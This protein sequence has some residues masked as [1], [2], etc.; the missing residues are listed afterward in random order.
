MP[1]VLTGFETRRRETPASRTSNDL[2]VDVPASPADRFSWMLLSRARGL[3]ADPAWTASGTERQAPS[4]LRRLLWLMLWPALA[5]TAGCGPDVDS[6]TASPTTQTASVPEATPEAV[7]RFCGDCHATPPPESFP[8]DAW[9]HEV[10]QGYNF[11]YESLRTDLQP[12][13]LQATVNFFVSRAPQRLAECVPPRPPSKTVELQRP[14]APPIPAAAHVRWLDSDSG[15]PGLWVCDMGGGAVWNATWN[16]NRAEFAWH[17]V[18]DVPHPCR[19]T[20]CDVDGSATPQLVVADLGS[21]LPEDHDRGSVWWLRRSPV[22]QASWTAEPLATGLARV[23]DVRPIDVEGDGDQDLIVAEFGWRKSGQ[24]RLLV[25]Q[26][27]DADGVPQFESRTIDKRHGAIHVPVIDL[28]ADGDLDFVALIAQE[29]EAIVAFLNDGQGEFT[30]QVLYR[31]NDPAFGSSGIELVDF[32]GDGDQDILYTNGDSFDSAMARNVHGVRW[33]ENRGDLQFA[34][35]EIGRLPGVHSAK[36]VDA[37]A[38]GDLDVIACVLLPEAVLSGEQR[39]FD[40]IV[41]FERQENGE[42]VGRSILADACQ[43]VSGEVADVN[44]DGRLEFLT[45]PFHWDQ[46]PTEQ[47][48]WVQL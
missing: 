26:G 23:C 21:F 38:D 42:F 19:V 30:P 41:L 9:P 18:A 20:P 1:G 44:R 39:R 48:I 16:D 36:A 17:K 27:N 6:G 32:D 7:E 12:P 33:L 14:A 47:V 2:V 35:H 11:Y 24:I 22:D 28:D 29:H 37:D 4:R 13:P 31:A 25:N 5:T 10:E 3:N 43:F 8:R 34:P 46:R 15:M 45:L 40:G